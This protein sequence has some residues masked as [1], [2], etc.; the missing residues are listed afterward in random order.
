MKTSNVICACTIMVADYSPFVYPQVRP[1]VSLETSAYVVLITQRAWVF[2]I[3]SF[4]LGLSLVAPHCHLQPKNSPADLDP[5]VK[6][7]SIWCQ[8]V[9]KTYFTN[10]TNEWAVQIKY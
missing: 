3:N 7:K 4:T 6:S 10:S 1:T 2:L 5:N 8:Q 9:E